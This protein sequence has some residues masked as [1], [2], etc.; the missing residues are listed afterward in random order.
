MNLSEK[1]V[2]TNGNIFTSD[3]FLPFADTMVTE[4]GRILWIGHAGDLPEEYSRGLSVTDLEGRRVIPGFVDAHMHPVMLADCRKQITVMPPE[5]CSI[6]SLAEAVRRRREEQG[7]GKWILGWGYD[8]QGLAEK[9]APNRYDLDLA[10]SDAPVALTRT[11]AHI[12][13]VNSMALKLAGISRDTPDPPGGEIERDESGEPTGILKENARHLL[14]PFLPAGTAE[15][16]AEHLAELGRHLASQGVTSICDMGDLDGADNLPV[17]QDAVKRGFRQRTGIYYLWDFFADRPDFR[18]LPEQLDRSR[19]IFTAGL[20][21]I[22][23]GSI[24]GR[25]AWMSRPYCGAEE[26]FGISV[27]SDDLLE[28]AIRFCRENHCQLSIHAMGGRAISRV[29]DR[30][31]A[32]EAWTPSGIPYVRIE[33]VTEPSPESMKKAARHGISFVSQPIFP[34]AESR[35][36]LK[37]LGGERLRQCYPYRNMLR[38]GV[39][40]GFST[41]APA[42][43]WSDPSDPFPGLKFA[44]TRTA[45]DGTDCGQDQALNA[46]ASIRLYTR[47]AA[48]AAGIPGVGVLAPGYQADFAVLSDDILALPPEEI[49]RVKVI[50]TRIGGE[51]VY[52]R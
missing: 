38:A 23:D 32:E 37:N 50:E 36:Y 11:C 30:V 14:A 28:S 10:C 20:K 13:C 4:N 43:F 29:T 5:I 17:F 41:D 47:G 15:A 35:S 34:Y 6:A 52:A 48:Q 46:A 40:L 39:T 3:D 24:S 49:D 45:A 12:R 44:V 51:C 22:A 27:L 2:F 8:E 42:T 16:K 33:H 7:P 25:T 18:I 31:C 26:E 9:R 19:Q 1:H 21:L